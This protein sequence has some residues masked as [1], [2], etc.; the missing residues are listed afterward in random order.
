MGRETFR[1]SEKYEYQFVRRNHPSRRARYHWFDV[2]LGVGICTC[3][4]CEGE[5]R[6]WRSEGEG[7]QSENKNGE[8]EKSGLKTSKGKVPG[9][10]TLPLRKP[11]VGG[12]A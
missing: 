7:D 10:D 5:T 12:I 1:E 4:D 2:W 6:G 9:Q 8:A 3:F 11:R